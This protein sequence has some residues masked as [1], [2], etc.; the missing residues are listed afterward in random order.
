VTY[1]SKWDDATDSCVFTLPVLW[2]YLD[3]LMFGTV[4]VLTLLFL[5][6]F[7]KENVASGVLNGKADYTVFRII[8]VSSVTF[9][10]TIFAI[11]IND[12]IPSI[13][14]TSS[15]VD[16]TTDILSMMRIFTHPSTESIVWK[17]IPLAKGTANRQAAPSRTSS[18]SSNDTT[19]PVAKVLKKIKTWRKNEA[20]PE[21]EFRPTSKFH[22]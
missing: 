5:M 8:F 6:Y 19:S 16:I 12:Q 3:E 21:I 17:G 13:G 14:L 20:E 7:Y 15:I 2:G 1:E 4:D 18:S 10:V 22:P 9:I 11:I